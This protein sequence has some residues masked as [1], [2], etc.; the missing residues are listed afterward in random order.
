MWI[1]EYKAKELALELV[2]VIEKHV[3]SKVY[4]IT[5]TKQVDKPIS[6]HAYIDGSSVSEIISVT[7]EVSKA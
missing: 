6:V 4:Q 3:E 5:I 1:N 7:F 2:E